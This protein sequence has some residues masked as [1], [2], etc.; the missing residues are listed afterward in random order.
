MSASQLATY[1]SI[2]W[3]AGSLIEIRPLPT[4]R[5]DAMPGW[6]HQ[7]WCLAEAVPTLYDELLQANTEGQANIFAGVLPRVA[8]GGSK[9]ADCAPGCVVWA[10]ADGMTPDALRQSIADVGLPPAAMLIDSGHGAHA[11]W[12]LNGVVFPQKLSELVGDLAAMLKTDPSVRNPSRIL[13]LPGFTN[14]KP[15]AAPCCMVESDSSCTYD[16]L[17]L[18]T[19]VPKA[20]ATIPAPP[21]SG[22]RSDACARAAAYIA[23][24]PGSTE[25]GRNMAAYKVSCVLRNDFQLP[26][27]EAR[28]LLEQWNAAANN[29]PL[30]A[31][32]LDAVIQSGGKYA[33]KVP[34]CK[35][36]HAAPP[37]A[38]AAEAIP[39]PDDAA[40]R[41]P[42]IF[43]AE[44]SG[45]SYTLSLPWPRLS[46]MTNAGRPGTV[47]VLAGPSGKGKSWMWLQVAIHFRWAHGVSFAYLPLEGTK[48][49]WERRILAYMAHDWTVLDITP[50]GAARRAEL[51]E[52]YSGDLPELM[53]GVCDNPAMPRDDSVPEISSDMV[54]DWIGRAAK[55]HRVVAVDPLSQIDWESRG[56][57]EN[58]AQAAFMRRCLGMAAST[59]STIVLVAHT[60]KR[61]GAAGQI[62]IT[63]EDVQGSKMLTNLADTVL[64]L[65]SHDRRESEVYDGTT[66]IR[67]IMHSKTV[68][69]GKA[70]HGRG[71]GARLAFEFEG[72]HLMERGVIVPKQKKVG[73]T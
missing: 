44:A 58:R 49:D 9:D 25:G 35:A 27:S 16:F 56:A 70:R 6:V 64:L 37:P 63:Q 68:T 59:G 33:L 61:P 72:P 11:Y 32:E 28:T 52:K 24:I 4:Q 18:R 46:E 66:I 31:K 55:T 45:A 40:S 60:I 54:L 3:P 73:R 42:D 38:A 23:R 47:C 12:K 19:M 34:G 71:D 65:D 36:G 57:R 22:P 30:P 7:S 13:R 14:H 62:G 67:P 1:A 21:P 5:G 50:E 26:A 69:I 8:D 41:L 17:L 20:S 43:A 15:P 53:C 29:P 2:V 48:A 39:L 51:Y 10:D